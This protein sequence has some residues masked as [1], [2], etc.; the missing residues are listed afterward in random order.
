[1]TPPYEKLSFLV[2]YSSSKKFMGRVTRERKLI[3]LRRVT[4]WEPLR[5]T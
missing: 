2:Q 1:L 3:E 5:K 4:V